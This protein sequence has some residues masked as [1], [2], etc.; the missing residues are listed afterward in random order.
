MRKAWLYALGWAAACAAQGAALVPPALE[1]P[2]LAVRAPD[3]VV[4]LAGAAA[5]TRLVAVGEHGV[6]ALSDDQG[7][8]WRQARAVPT[9]VTLTAVAFADARQGWAVGHAGMILRTQ[10]GGETWTRQADGRNL[11]QAAVAAASKPGAPAQRASAQRLLDEGPDKPLL[12]LHFLDAQRGFAVGAYGLF[13]ETDDGGTTWRSAMERLDNPKGL[14]LYAIRSDG[15]TLYIAGEQGLLLRSDDRGA[16][17]RRLASP[18]AGSWFTLAVPRP[19]AVIA[20][21]LRGN[22][23][24]SFDRGVGW[25]KME[26][27]ASAS[28]VS[29]VPGANGDVVLANQAGQLL[30]GRGATLQPLQVPPLP[31]AAGILPLAGGGLLVLGFNGVQRLPA[32]GAR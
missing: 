12:D 19:G 5:G 17:F 16:S 10:D 11:A 2:A 13:F 22:A 21:G 7:A 23:F 28:I 4:L 9:S 30:A 3:R 25:T 24:A 31:P 32:G 20:A 15:D 1:R 14:H 26:G 29:A 8:R 6:V 27:G 18:Y